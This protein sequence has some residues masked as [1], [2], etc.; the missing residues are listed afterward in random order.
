MKYY[1]YP[2]PRGTEVA[3]DVDSINVS[4]YGGGGGSGNVV[5][6]PIEE[7]DSSTR[8]LG[9]K[10][11]T[12]SYN[13]VKNA[14]DAGK[15]I[16]FERVENEESSITVNRSVSFGFQYTGEEYMLGVTTLEANE[17]VSSSLFIS[18]SPDDPMIE[19]Q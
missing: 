11:K 1:N 13:T 14:Y 12:V 5:I 3:E 7:E 10:K 17:A 16:F 6:F 9:K 2:D 18:Y 4:Q 19:R 15:T 8:G